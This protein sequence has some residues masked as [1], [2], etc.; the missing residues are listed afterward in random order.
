VKDL[1]NESYKPLK[2]IDEYKRWKDF[3]CSGLAEPIL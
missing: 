3:P 2:E 1:Y